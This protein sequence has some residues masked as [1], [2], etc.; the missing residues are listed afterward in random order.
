LK[1]LSN[2]ELVMENP[3]E[4]LGSTNQM[5]KSLGIQKNVRRPNNRKKQSKKKYKK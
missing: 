5:L 4:E 1:E 2:G 3:E